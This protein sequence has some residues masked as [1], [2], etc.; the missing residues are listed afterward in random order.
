MMRIGR[1]RRG[2]GSGERR[3]GSAAIDRAYSITMHTIPR[4]SVVAAL[5]LVALVAPAHAGEPDYATAFAG[6]RACFEV[7][8]LKADR[9]VVRH[10][11]AECAARMSP[12]STFKVP[13]ALMA[14]DR[15]VLTDENSSFKWDGH[16]YDREAWNA[17]HT[18]ASW[19]KNSVVWFSQRL[20]PLLGAKAVRDYLARFEYG[21][22]DMAGGLTRFWLESTLRISPDEQLRFWKRFMR[23]E[24]PVSARALD[25]T[26]KI[27]LIET[28]PNGWT[29][30][31]K[32]G[33]GARIG[34]FAG[35]I[36]N[37][38]R[39]YL[40]VT[41]IVETGKPASGEPRG[42]MTRDLT[43]KLLGEMGLY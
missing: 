38:E 32:T 37:G 17:D 3:R 11:G 43:K 1:P 5:S 24:L 4:V 15:G 16:H 25:L 19:M 26:K 27:T 14:F 29:L 8:D 2:A 41:R 39:E 18:A 28:S 23:G 7:Y 12:C 42:P 10:G 31:G 6:R 13:L 20:T 33:S 34:W 22:R 21:N 9:I 36:A 30:H 35:H 40:V